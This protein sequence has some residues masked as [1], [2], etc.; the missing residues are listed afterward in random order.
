MV[1]KHVTDADVL[2]SFTQALVSRSAR[3]GL[4]FMVHVNAGRV[5]PSH[6]SS[7]WYF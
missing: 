6:A 5:V 2:T 4:V 7:A 1:S 3:A